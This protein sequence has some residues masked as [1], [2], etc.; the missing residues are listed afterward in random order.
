[1]QT[2]ALCML[3][4]LVVEGHGTLPVH[5]SSKTIRKE[6]KKPVHPK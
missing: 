1:M 5:I 2:F 4:L 6:E 3:S